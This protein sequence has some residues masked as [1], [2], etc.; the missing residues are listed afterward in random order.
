MSSHDWLKEF[1]PKTVADLA[2]HPKKI[3]ELEEWIEESGEYENSILLL[4]GPAGSGKTTTIKLIAKNMG[5]DVIEWITPMDVEWSELGDS[6]NG[7]F[8]ENQVDKFRDFLFRASRYSSLLEKDTKKLII[9]EDLPNT[10]FKQTEKFEE[11][12]R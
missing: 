4:T 12:L 6:E 7:T 9:V 1:T 5:F 3:E 8:S 11:V 2:I 10:F